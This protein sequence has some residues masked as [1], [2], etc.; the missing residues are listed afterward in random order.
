MP[1]YVIGPSINGPVK[2]GVSNDI[3]KRVKELQTSHYEQLHVWGEGSA[4]YWKDKKKVAIEAGA[5]ERYLH[6][7]L[8]EHRIFPRHEWFKLAPHHIISPYVS[9]AGQSLYGYGHPQQVYDVRLRWRRSA[10]YRAANKPDHYSHQLHL[11]F[12]Q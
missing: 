4:F 2:I 5:V 8:K 7:V 3:E 11:N 12:A 1:V 6:R 9:L 10:C